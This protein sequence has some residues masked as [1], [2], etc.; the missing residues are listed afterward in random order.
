MTDIYLDKTNHDI[1]LDGRDL[2][3]TT[4]DEDVVQRLTVRLQ[5]LLDE[6]FLNTSR[7]IQFTQ[8]IIEAAKGDLK[9]LHSLYR[10]EISNTEGV[11]SIDTLE[12]N[13]DGDERILS[14]V[15][16]VNQTTDVSLE[17]NI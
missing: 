1:V 17:V 12:L 9:F 3:L 8:T 5:F 11:E 16:K 15:L 6:W 7:G 2:R 14:I 4:S 10:K 13:I